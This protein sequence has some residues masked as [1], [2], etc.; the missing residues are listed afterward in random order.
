MFYLFFELTVGDNDLARLGLY[1]VILYN[2]LSSVR[3]FIIVES[4]AGVES[5]TCVD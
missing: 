4:S 3:K 1:A 5:V 2:S